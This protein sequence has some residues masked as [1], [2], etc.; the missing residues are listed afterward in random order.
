MGLKIGEPAKII[1]DC[2]ESGVAPVTAKVKTPSGETQ[3]V[4]FEPTTE[5]PQH[6]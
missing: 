3:D 6:L 4:K 1:V 5:K 2:S